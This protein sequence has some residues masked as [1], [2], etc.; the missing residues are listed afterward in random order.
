MS[1]STRAARCARRQGGQRRQHPAATLGGHAEVGGVLGAVGGDQRAPATAVLEVVRQG[2]RTPYL[3]GTQPVQARVD[4][5]PVQPGGDGGLAPE[6]AGAPVGRDQAVLEA[7]GCVLGVAHG[8]HGHRPQPVAVA[9]EELA[10][11]VRV[12]V[13]VGREELGVRQVARHAG[14]PST[15]TSATSPRKPP[16]AAGSEVSQ[17]VT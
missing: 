9:G 6:G 16:S 5:D 8:A 2:L 11:G 1:T 13:D 12:P 14:V 7:V 3:G 15:L 4:H 17:R 10:E